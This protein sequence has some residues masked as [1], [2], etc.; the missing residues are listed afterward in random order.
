MLLRTGVFEEQTAEGWSGNGY[1]WTSIARVIVDEKLPGL[2]DDQ[3]FDPE[4]CMF[5]AN[6]PLDALKQLGGE[7]KK[8]F[9]DEDLLRDVLSRAALD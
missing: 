8:V 1:D 4:A 2:K 3:E 7:L 6:G 5:S 9:D